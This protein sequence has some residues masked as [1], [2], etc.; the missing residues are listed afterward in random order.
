MKWSKEFRILKAT[1]SY[2]LNDSID[3]MFMLLLDVFYQNN[4]YRKCPEKLGRLIVRS[5]F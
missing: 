5:T 2:Y 4:Y 1:D 3:S